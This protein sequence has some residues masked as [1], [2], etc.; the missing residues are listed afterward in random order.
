MQGRQEVVTMADASQAIQDWYTRRLQEY[1]SRRYRAYLRGKETKGKYNEL[2]RSATWIKRADHGQLPEEVRAAHGYYRKHFEETDLGSA[3]V[4]RVSAN[5]NPI[6]AIRVTTDG[7]DGFLEVYDS[8]GTFVAAARRY[9]EVVAWGSQAWLREQATHPWDLPPELQDAHHRTLWGQPVA[10]IHCRETCDHACPASPPGSC[11]E[12]AG[13]LQADGS[14]H[15][16]SR[17]DFSWGGEPK[18]PA[19]PAPAQPQIE[20]WLVE[21]HYTHGQDFP[22][23]VLLT[24]VTINT[25]DGSVTVP[26]A[27]IQ[28]IDFAPRPSSASKKGAKKPRPLDL[29]LTTDAQWTGTIEGDPWQ[30]A[31][32]DYTTELHFASMTRL[33]KRITLEKDA[34]AFGTKRQFRLRGRVDGFLCGTNPYSLISCLATAAVHAGVLQPGQPGVVQVEIV[35]S[36]PRFEGST[37]NGLTSESFDLPDEEGAFRILNPADK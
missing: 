18:P 26:V 5:R 28:Q 15:R 3:G 31:V 11:I 4:Y 20:P 33:I 16:C 37:R 21:V 1:F 2:G 34:N 32:Q 10:G 24:E 13:H 19:P 6:Y 27:D 36:P 14:P 29:L 35:P 8:K 17:C 25:A 22:Q 12:R 9:I 30:A 23:R 7:D